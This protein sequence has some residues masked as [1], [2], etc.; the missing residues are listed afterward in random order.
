M[1]DKQITQCQLPSSLTNL[2]DGWWF[3]TDVKPS[4]LCWKKAQGRDVL[5][6]NL[7]TRGPGQG[8]QQKGTRGE[9]ASL[10]G[11]MGTERAEPPEGAAGAL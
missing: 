8:G 6:G 3:V 7:P 1:S 2:P 4:V 5:I 10:S 11:L 9:E